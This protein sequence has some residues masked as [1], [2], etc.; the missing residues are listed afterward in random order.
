M[1][2]RQVRVIR[3]DGSVD[4][5]TG[6]LMR[7]LA[8]ADAFRDSGAEV[9]FVC[10]EI[11]GVL[12][13]I[14]FRENFRVWRIDADIGS[15]EDAEQTVLLTLAIP[16]TDQENIILVLDGYRFAEGFQLIV[17][18]SGLK[19]LVVDDYRH[20]E[21]YHANW[22]LNQNTPYLWRLN[23]RHGE[24]TKFLMGGRYAMLRKEFL[25]YLGKPRAI[26]PIARNILVTMG[27]SDPDNLTIDV[28]RA[29][30]EAGLSARVVVG[31]SNPHLEQLKGFIA[32]NRCFGGVIELV[33]A[34]NR[35]ADLMSWADVAV[36]SAGSTAWELSFMGVPSIY[37]KGAE[38]QRVVL[39]TIEQMSIGVCVNEGGLPLNVEYLK[40][41][42][43]ELV[44]DEGR[45]RELSERAR[46]VVDGYGCR[47]IVGITAK[48]APGSGA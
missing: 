41:H 47:R 36:A 20:A 11:P 38:N 19:Q 12:E 33:L 23:Y 6:H 35:M 42:I 10:A 1:S 31:G 7:M 13:E 46:K 34:T 48:F 24:G 28:I 44:N 30:K 5:G 21:F 37:L 43:V 4:I 39:E 40:E 32:E 16:D 2:E 17:K 25:S 9:H 22:L 14:L 26:S 18:R 29:L 45:R 15:S 3:A 8:L 27:G